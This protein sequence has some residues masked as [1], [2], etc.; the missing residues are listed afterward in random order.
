MTNKI[1]YEVK[2]EKSLKIILAAIAVGLIMNV[3]A[4][5]IYMEMF[6]IKEALADVQNIMG[7]LDVRLSGSVRLK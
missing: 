6:G 3:F 5:P 1:E 7:G 4:S 2:I